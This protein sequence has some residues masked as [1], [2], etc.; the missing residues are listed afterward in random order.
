MWRLEARGAASF[1]GLHPTTFSNL[2][3]L[4]PPFKRKDATFCILQMIQ[5]DAPRTQTRISATNSLLI[6]GTKRRMEAEYSYS[7]SS[8]I[9]KSFRPA[10]VTDHPYQLVHILGQVPVILTQTGGSLYT[11]CGVFTV[12]GEVS[13]LNCAS[14]LFRLFQWY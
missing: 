13:V 12:S 7:A 3:Q 14:A 5:Q 2:C 9:G 11:S 6:V 4:I 8:P 1:P 10:I